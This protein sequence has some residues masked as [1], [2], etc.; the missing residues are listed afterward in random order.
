MDEFSQ[1]NAEE[2][3]FY[4]ENYFTRKNEERKTLRKLSFFSGTA[5]ILYVVIQNV[6]V[7]ALEGL[8]LLTLYSKNVFFRGGIDIVLTL[9]GI[10]LPFMLM[11]K[12]MKQVSGEAEPVLAEPV[13]SRSLFIFGMLGC[14]G[15]VMLSNIVSSYITAIISALGYE[16]TAPEISTAEGVAGFLINML[17]VCILAAVVEE[18]CLRGQVLGNLRFYGDV[19]AIVMSASIFGLMHSTLIQV[20]FAM[21][22]GIALGFFTLKCN[23][24]WPAVVAHGINN[25]LSIVI[26]YLIEIIGEEKGMLLYGYAIYALILIGMVSCVLFSMN[27]HKSPLRKPQTILTLSEKL[28]SFIFSLPIIIAFLLMVLITAESISWRV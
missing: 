20:P 26:S 2:A 22:S 16:L 13:K 12:K 24:I 15:C 7:T 9:L 10:L 8:D 25:G 27:S 5:V 23:S 19:F 18:Y 14:T 17:K 11:G 4:T 6:I 21:L 28:S 3:A 1:L